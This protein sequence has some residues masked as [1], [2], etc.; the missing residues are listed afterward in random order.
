MISLWGEKTNLLGSSSTTSRN[1][2]RS[3]KDSTLPP[4]SPSSV[5]RSY[6]YWT[7]VFP[8]IRRSLCQEYLEDRLSRSMIRC[9]RVSITRKRLSMLLRW[10]SGMERS[11]PFLWSKGSPNW[12]ISE[13][14]Y[15]SM[16]RTNPRSWTIMSLRRL[17]KRYIYRPYKHNL[18]LIFIQRGVTCREV[19]RD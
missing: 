8:R 4:P 2:R 1:G 18:Y 17:R 16:G 6:V 13:I 11:K 5:R 12:I 3:G 9:L 10:P 14:N 15:Y 19:R 7:E